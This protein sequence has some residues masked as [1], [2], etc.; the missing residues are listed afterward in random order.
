[1]KSREWLVCI[2]FD[3]SSTLAMQDET[4]SFVITLFVDWRSS[5]SPSFSTFSSAFSDTFL[6]TLFFIARCTFC[7][8]TCFVNETNPNFK[9]N[10]L[11]ETHK[12]KQSSLEN[13]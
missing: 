7:R 3:T 12:L 8:K 6:H 5:Q 4:I 11:L 10:P 2:I 9:F 13:L 1:M